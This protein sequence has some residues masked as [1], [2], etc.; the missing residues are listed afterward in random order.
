M[1]S[2]ER[3]DKWFKSFTDR[4]KVEGALDPMLD[5]KF[6]HS[7]RVS[8]IC[9]EIASSLSW[10]E[11]GDSWL[12]FTAGLLHDVGRFPQYSKFRTFFDSI[13]ADHGELGAEILSEEFDWDGLPVNFRDNILAAVRFH[14]KKTVPADL[15]LGPY[16]WACLVRDSDKIDIYRMVQERIENGTIF[17]MLP[18]HQTADGLSSELVEEVRR[19][20]SGSYSNARSL[21]DYRLIQLTWGCDLNF[22]VSVAT[23]RD[24][25]IIEKIRDDL[26]PYGISDLIDELTDRIYSM[27]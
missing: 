13:S 4:Y 22:P 8:A 18:R 19:T 9:S 14:N 11:D 26:Y 7:K 23:L 17:E 24:E 1:F 10:D 25:N 2:T 3:T 5:L 27:A 21:E 12:A 15:K 16:K 6:K 20:G